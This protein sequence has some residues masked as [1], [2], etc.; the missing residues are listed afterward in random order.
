MDAVTALPVEVQ[1]K[2]EALAK[3]IDSLQRADYAADL[4]NALRAAGL[5]TVSEW[6]LSRQD[7]LPMT[8]G[9]IAMNEMLHSF[10]LA[11]EFLQN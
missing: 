9:T 5:P 1:A 2:I 3:H 8:E 10:D 7:I 11:Y 4:T 6:T